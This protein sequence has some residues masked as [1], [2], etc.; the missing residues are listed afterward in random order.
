MSRGPTPTA[1]RSTTATSNRDES[2]GTFTPIGARARALNR[3][4]DYGAG[5]VENQL[6][7]W[8]KAG[9]LAGAP[10]DP[11]AAPKL[12]AWDDTSQSTD[13]RARAYLEGNCAHCHNATG[14]ASTS[15]LFLAASDTDALHFGVCK[16]PLSAG[17][18]VGMRQFDIVPGDPD[19]SILSYRM[20]VTDP[21]VAMPQI[22]R[23]VVHA[24]GL[25]LVRQWITALPKA[26]CSK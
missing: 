20:S 23:D 19:A 26:P 7:H 13:T 3:D 11:S 25:D 5:V 21:G 18:M 4:Y 2:N 9:I 8:T 12:A 1:S 14:S 6:A 22:G 15:G 17:G 16:E 24:E 10:S